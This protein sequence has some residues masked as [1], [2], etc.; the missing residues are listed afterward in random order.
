MTHKDFVDW[1]SHPVT[2]E[3]IRQ[4]NIRKQL[5]QDELGVSAGLDPLHDRFRA[6]AIAGYNDLTEI[7][8]EEG[9]K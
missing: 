4:L 9:D 1:K 7:D 8:F 2:K 3:I 5:L 6:G